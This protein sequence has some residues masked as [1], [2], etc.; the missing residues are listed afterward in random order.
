MAIA[1]AIPCAA[2]DQYHREIEKTDRDGLA[3]IELAG[4]RQDLFVQRFRGVELPGSIG[5]ATP[6]L[7][8]VALAALSSSCGGD[9]AWCDRECA[10]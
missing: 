7:A 1:G 9:G 6:Y 8:V 10:A 5:S 3:I 4:E 2:A